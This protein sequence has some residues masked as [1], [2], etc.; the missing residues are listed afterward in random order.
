MFALAIS[1]V[2]GTI[3]MFL[4]GSRIRVMVMVVPIPFNGLGQGQA[5]WIREGDECGT[6]GRNYETVHAR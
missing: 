2:L 1:L 6:Y 3:M 5:K 4:V